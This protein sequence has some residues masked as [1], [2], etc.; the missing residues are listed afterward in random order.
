MNKTDIKKIESLLKK[1]NIKKLKPNNFKKFGSSR[2]LYNF[3]IDNV[4]DY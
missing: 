3:N 1:G 4:A 2:K